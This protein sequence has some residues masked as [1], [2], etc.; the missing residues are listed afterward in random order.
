MRN[1]LWTEQY[2]PTTTAEYVFVDARQRQQVL[3]WIKDGSIP[4]LLMSGE[5]GTGKT[6]LAKVLINELG[7]EPYDIMEIN[8]SREN[9]VEVVRQKIN[10]FAQT[11]PF[12]TFKVVLLDEADYTSPEFQAALRH[13]MEAYA[14]TVR[15]ILTCNYSGKIIPALK[16]RCHEMHIAKTDLVDFTTRAAT[17]L[18]SENVDFDLDVLDTYVRVCYPDLRKCLNTLQSNSG[19]GKLVAPVATGSD[20]NELLMEATTLFK[21]KKYLDGRKMLMQYLS[22]YPTRVEDVYVW[23]YRNV[24]LWGDTTAKKDQA[25]III[26]NGLA[27]LPMVGIP[28]IA[29]AASL[30]ELTSI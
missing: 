6:T 23:C 28:E 22:L 15:F 14:T 9:G 8:A 17:I 20:E 5:P 2:R 30:S 26:R 1:R 4:H 18:V 3:G 25:I 16:S 7:I 13:D 24:D 29:L 21:N 12:G 10:A 11:M 19:S 27:S